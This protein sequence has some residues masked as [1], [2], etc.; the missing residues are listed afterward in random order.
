MST[1]E[2][3]IRGKSQREI[4]HIHETLAEAAWK[5]RSFNEARVSLRTPYARI[6]VTHLSFIEQQSQ[7]SVTISKCCVPNGE[8]V[9]R[10][11]LQEHLDSACEI[12]EAYNESSLSARTWCLIGSLSVEVDDF[13]AAATSYERALELANDVG[14]SSLVWVATVNLAVCGVRTGDANTA[15]SHARRA[16]VEAEAANELGIVLAAHSIR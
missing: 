6:L 10:R 1:W 5:Q 7:R 9:C 16:F 12:W 8:V 4:A 14:D 11:P 13:E 2:Q 3:K 15:A